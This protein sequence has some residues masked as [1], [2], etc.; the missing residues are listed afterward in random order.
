MVSGVWRVAAVRERPGAGVNARA[1]TSNNP[2]LPLSGLDT[3]ITRAGLY[4]DGAGPLTVLSSGCELVGG[5]VPR[6]GE[7]V[8]SK[9]RFSAFW[10]THLASLLRRLGA[11]HVVITGVQT[12]NCIRATAFDAIAEDF[13]DVSVVADAT[14]SA[15]PTVQAANLHDLRA[16]GVHT[17][18]LAEW[19]ASLGGGGGLLGTLFGR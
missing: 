4:R 3:E 16:V 6:G 12:P 14:A 7:H 8:V 18:T 9:K 15:T 10:G 1:P 5:L 19:K 11:T 13:I 2:S 17:P